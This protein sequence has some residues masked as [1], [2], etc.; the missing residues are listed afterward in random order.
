MSH[1]PVSNSN[2]SAPHLGGHLQDKYPFAGKVICSII[3]AG[4]NDSYLIDDGVEKF[5]FRVYSLGWRTATEILEEIRLLQLLK[6]NNISISY[7]I[8]DCNNSFIQ[9]LNAPEGNRY[10]V[11]FSFAKGEKLHSFSADVHGSI[12]ELMAQLH[13]ITTNVHLNRSTYT[14]TVLIVE[15]L[16]QISQFLS[17]DTAEMAFMKAMQQYLLG[18]FQDV[19]TKNLRRGAVHLD[20]WFDN[21]NIDQDG[22]VTIFDF[23]FCGNGW[24][25]MDVA[26]YMLQVYSTERDEQECQA[27]LDSFFKGYESITQITAE[28]RRLLPA[29]GVSLYFFYLGVQCRRYDNWSN[30]FLSESYLKRFI[31]G[32]VKRY[33]DIHKMNIT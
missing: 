9:V 4:I 23:D 24:L 5:V 29:L 10:G 30:S 21:L 18:E 1:F 14:P 27:K 16:S 31:N 12:G 3:R 28:E 19:K 25:C 17:A 7:P 22:A 15:P 8:A 13:T 33:A 32:L 26:Y 11:L 20:I 6:V 2:L